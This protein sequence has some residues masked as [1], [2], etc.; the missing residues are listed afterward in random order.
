MKYQELAPHSR[1]W[2]YQSNRKLTEK[3]V[4]EIESR[5]DEFI[6]NWNAHGAALSSAF[7]LLENTFLVF[8]VDESLAKASGC[9]IDSSVGFVKHIE[10][11]FN[12]DLFNRLNVAYEQEGDLELTSMANFQELLKV[13]KVTEDTLVYNNLVATKGEFESNWKTAVKESWHARL[14]S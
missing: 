3:E 9:S 5:A 7:A 8:F 13:G 12:L 11:A 4:N 6:A 10:K 2:I 14:L 1:V